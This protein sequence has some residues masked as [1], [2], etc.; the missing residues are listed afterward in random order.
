M[1]NYI[2]VKN[3]KEMLHCYPDAPDEV[4]FLKNMHRH[5]FHFKTYI[6]IF[7]NDRDL[8]FIMVK[9]FIDKL[10]ITMDKNLLNKSCEMLADILAEQIHIKY[11]GRKI[12][13]SVSEDNENGI[14]KKYNFN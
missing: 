11:T 6:E 5:I 2:W 9:R 12:K 7:H 1:T 3:Q 10:L 8:E 14:I 4:S 13:I